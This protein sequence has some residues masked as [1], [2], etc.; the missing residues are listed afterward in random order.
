MIYETCCLNKQIISSFL[1]S[2]GIVFLI[3][4]DLILAAIYLR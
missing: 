1:L 3:H 4:D 2:A